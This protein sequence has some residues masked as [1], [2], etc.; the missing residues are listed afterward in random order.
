M[1]V[2]AA[3]RRILGGDLDAL[4]RVAAQLGSDPAARHAW[5]L[6]LTSLLEAILV[7][8]VDAAAIAV[9]REQP[10]WNLFT[11]EQ[12]RD[13]VAAL[14]SLGYRFD[15]LG[16]WLDNRVPAQRELSMAVAHAG[17]EPMRVRRWPAGAEV[18]E[19]L[20]DAHV[21]GGDYIAAIAPGLTVRELRLI[22]GRDA[23]ALA[24]VWEAWDRV[25][26]LLLADRTS[27]Q[28]AA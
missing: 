18:A 23:D 17:L 21:L 4:T 2:G 10:F 9:P 20:R 27:A 25:R 5:E 26:P 28:G 12:S 15:G 8:A 11:T 24:D 16:G 19:L 7:R 14:S 13:I 1:P 22:L 3:I 6:R